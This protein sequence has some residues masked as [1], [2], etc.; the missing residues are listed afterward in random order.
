[1]ITRI[2]DKALSQA[3]TYAIN[4]KI[5]K[6]GS[7]AFLRIDTV[8]KRIEMSLELL[9]ENEPIQVSIQRYRFQESDGRFFLSAE[10]IETSRKWIDIAAREYLL[11]QRVEIPARYAGLIRR[12]L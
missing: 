5:E 3:I 10:G 4:R 11:S 2:K 8:E 6:F 1:M 7:V 12:F 9:G